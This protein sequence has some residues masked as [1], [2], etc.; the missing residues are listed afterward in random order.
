MSW[1]RTIE[2][3]CRYVGELE[4]NL[5]EADSLIS[6]HRSKIDDNLPESWPKGSILKK[7]IDRHTKRVVS[8]QIRELSRHR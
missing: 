5:A 6:T 8:E 7:A 1:Q 4:T 2:D 3:L